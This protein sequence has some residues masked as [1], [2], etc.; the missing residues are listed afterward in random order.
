M[1]VYFLRHG[2]TDWNKA[3]RWQSRSEVPLN[4][5]GKAQS[6]AVAMALQGLSQQPGKSP[7]T[8][9]CSPMGRAQQ[10]AVEVGTHLSL[11]PEV[12]A[13]FIELDL[14]D[15]EGRLQTDLLHEEGARFEDWLHSYHRLA[16]PN[17]ESLQDGMKRARA[18]FLQHLNRVQAA[19]GDGLAIVAHQG[20]N[21][22]LKT[23]CCGQ[24]AESISDEQLA[25][26][27]QSNAQ[28]DVWQLDA[29]I[30]ASLNGQ[31][32]KRVDVDG[33]DYSSA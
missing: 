5:T 9:L 24:T 15:F 22:A 14:G 29:P 13:D 19:Q 2:Q 31:F 1:W 10:T 33:I 32:V 7:T 18:A 26:F 30:K 4:A 6:K 21:I 20:I 11:S 28:I 27:K 17:G 25:S 8:L 3:G 23:L 16:P 12:E